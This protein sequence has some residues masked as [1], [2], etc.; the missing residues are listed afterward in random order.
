MESDGYQLTLDDLFDYA[1]EFKVV[2]ENKSKMDSPVFK[3]IVTRLID[4]LLLT[5][6]LCIVV[7]YK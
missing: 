3:F 6:M 1:E 2:L 4:N 7:V 5:S